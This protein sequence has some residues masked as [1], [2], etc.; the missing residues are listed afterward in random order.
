MRNATVN[1][2]LCRDFETDNMILKQGSWRKFKKDAKRKQVYLFGA[3]KGCQEF[4]EVY[5]NKILIAGIIDNSPDRINKT[6]GGIRIY[7]K[8][9]IKSFTKNEVVLITSASY[10]NDIADELDLLGVENYYAYAVIEAKKFYWRM[11]YILASL[12]IWKFHRVKKNKILVW[13]H[14][15]PGSFSCHAK[16]IVQELIDEKVPCEIVWIT[17]YKQEKFPKEVKVVKASP[18]RLMIEHATSKIWI[19][20]FKKDKWMRKKKNQYYINTWHGSLSLKKLDFDTPVSSKT[21]LMR[22]VKDSEMID[23]RLSNSEFCSNMYRNAMKYKNEILEC[24]SPRLDKI[25]QGCKAVYTKLGIDS[26]SRLLMYAPTWHTITLTGGVAKDSELKMNFK[27]LRSMLIKKFGGDWYILVRPHPQASVVNTL[28]EQDMHVIDVS[29]YDDVYELLAETRILVS[30]Y[31]S[32]I[33]E[34]GFFN[35]AVFVVA[36]DYELYKQQQGIY[37]E[38]TELPYP[39]AYSF[40]E[41]LGNIETFDEEEYLQ[42][43]K[44]FHAKINLKETGEAS[45]IV[46]SKIK[47]VLM[48]NN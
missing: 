13:N 21:H 35:K 1:A 41:F 22:T 6:I 26:N 39:I 16:Y 37:F 11:F 32:L 12:F 47:S 5:G 19:D 24:G 3:G 40:P 34:A 36:E 27:E 42:K 33:F 38:F 48:Q 8:E 29:K 20:N 14:M 31:S 45:K 9:I 4:I 15:A 7:D 18:Y 28:D 23:L 30:D 2:V 44:L 17:N 46:V 25:K 43:L 10:M